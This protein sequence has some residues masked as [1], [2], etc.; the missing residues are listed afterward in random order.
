MIFNLFPTP[1]SY[2]KNFLN[3]D[4]IKLL[5]NYCLENKDVNA[6]QLILNDAVTSHKEHKDFLFEAVLNE[7]IPKDI[8]N[9]L[10]QEIINYSR[11]SGYG[12]VKI[13]NSWF[14][15]QNEGSVLTAH[16]HPQSIVSGAL[17][18]NVDEHSSPIY[19]HNP[20]PLSNF[21]CVSDSTEHG[22]KHVKV[23]PENGDLLLFPSW[24]Q[25]GSHYE[26]NQTPN[27]VVISFNT[28]C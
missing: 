25:H 1:V 19:L 15:I 27:R 5:F 17:Y 16:C 28:I 21:A 11:V 8:Y 24:L 2:T 10:L 23:T 7:N 14:N 26:Q 3:D 12:F 9:K 6:S 20:N 4:E 18:I 13:A 22:H